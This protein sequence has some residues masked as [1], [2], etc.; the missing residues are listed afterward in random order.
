[1]LWS[2]TIT[3]KGMGNKNI[4]IKLNDAVYCYV[5]VSISIL[6]ACPL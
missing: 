1:M 3:S 6:F 4:Q 5:C 2:E